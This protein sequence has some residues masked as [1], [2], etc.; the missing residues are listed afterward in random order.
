MI[1]FILGF[2]VGVVTGVPGL[3]CFAL[4]YN[5]NHSDK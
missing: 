2:L 3:I 4:A 5:K 1:N